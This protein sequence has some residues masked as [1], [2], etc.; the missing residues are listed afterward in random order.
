MTTVIIGLVVLVPAVTGMV[1]LYFKARAVEA[2]M[3][4]EEAR[5]P[6]PAADIARLGIGL[7]GTGGGSIG[8]Q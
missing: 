3:A 4:H 6:G 2:D 7:T 1:V 8:G 5:D